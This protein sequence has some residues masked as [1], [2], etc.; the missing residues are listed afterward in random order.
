MHPEAVEGLLEEGV[1][2]E[3]RLSLEALA[4]VGSG[5]QARRQGHRVADGEGGGVVRDECHQILPEVLLD[6]VVS[7][8]R[9]KV[10]RWT[11]QRAGN[12]SA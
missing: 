2:A 9:A 5:E 11:S 4:T 7:A 3:S 6:L 1:F 10:V 8:C 12:H